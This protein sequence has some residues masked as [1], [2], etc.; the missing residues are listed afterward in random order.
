MITCPS[1][2]LQILAPSSHETEAQWQKL[3]VKPLINYGLSE[4]KRQREL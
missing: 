3:F 4:V 1:E 2:G